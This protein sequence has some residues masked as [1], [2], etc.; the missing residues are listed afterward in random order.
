MEYDYICEIILSQGQ[1]KRISLY[2]KTVNAVASSRIPF[3]L[4]VVR[5][6][7]IRT[8]KAHAFWTDHSKIR[9][10]IF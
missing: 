6:S 3:D 9:C 2:L 1:F 5:A 8:A 7:L 4:S 10:Y